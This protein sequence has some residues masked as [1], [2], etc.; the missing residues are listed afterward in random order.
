MVRA[1]DA[2]DVLQD[3]AIRIYRNIGFLREPAVFQA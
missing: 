2:D 1:S 3:V